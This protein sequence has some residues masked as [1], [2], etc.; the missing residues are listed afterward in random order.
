VIQTAL[1]SLLPLGKLVLVGV[2]GARL[3]LDARGLLL[4]GTS[5]RGCTK[6]DADPRSFMPWLVRWQR[7][8]RFPIDR[9]VTP[10]RFTDIDETLADF[11]AGRLVKPV[12][13]FDEDAPGEAQ[14]LRGRPR[15]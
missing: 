12:L 7:E 5:I 10:R 15:V 14:R 9:I 13:V 2:G 6:G 1:D 11:A 3:E 8:G 4:G